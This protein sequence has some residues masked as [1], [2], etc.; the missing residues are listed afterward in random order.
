MRHVLSPFVGHAH[1]TF[2]TVSMLVVLLVGGSPAG[3]L[4][5][6]D[7]TEVGP[8]PASPEAADAYR[9]AANLQN[10]AEFTA[11]TDLWRTFLQQYPDDP[12]V[13]HAQYYLG[14]C[15]MQQDQMDEAATQFQQATNH[16]AD[17]KYVEES[18]LNWGWCRY[19]QGMRGENDQLAEAARIFAD[20]LARFPRGSFT[21]QALF[22]AGECCH[23]TG[24]PEQAT[25]YHQRLLEE[26]PKSPQRPDAMYALAVAAQDSSEHQRAE[27]L[28]Q[29][30]LSEYP[31]HELRAEMLLRY[32]EVLL[33]TGQMDAAKQRFAEAAAAPGFS[34]ADHAAMRVGACLE[35]SR[36]YSA[37]AAYYV[38]FSK[39]FPESKFLPGAALGAARSY[40]EA[41]QWA[42]AKTWYIKARELQPEWLGEASHWLARIALE[43]ADP[44]QAIAESRSAVEKLAPSD[45]WRTKLLLDIAD[46]LYAQPDRKEDAMRAYLRLADKFAASPEAG[47]ALYNAAYAALELGKLTEVRDWTAR[48]LEQFPEHERYP[49]TRHLQGEAAMLAGEFGSAEATFAKLIQDYPQHTDVDRWRT[50]RGAALQSLGRHDEA[51]QALAAAAEQMKSDEFQAEAIYR[52]AVSQSEQGDPALAITSLESALQKQ[53]RNPQADRMLLLLASLEKQQGRPDQAQ[54]HL[55]ALRDQ[56]PDSD[57]RPQATFQL[58]EQ[59]FLAGD[60]AGADPLYAELISSTPPSELVPLAIY[61]QA[62]VNLRQGK[63]KSAESLFSQ[64]I[65]KHAD[66]SIAPRSLQGRGI[67]RHRQR[68]YDAGLADCEAFLRTEPTADLKAD[69]LYVAGLCQIG[70]GQNAAAEE[71]LRRI[72]QE[73]ADYARRDHVIYEL[74]WLLKQPQPDASSEMFEQLARECPDSKLRAESLVH[75]ADGRMARQ[76]YTAAEEY[77]RQAVSSALTDTIAE[78]ALYKLGFLLLRNQEYAKSQQETER[79]LERFPEG[80][81]AAEGQF[82]LAEAHFHQKAYQEA[83]RH[84]EPLRGVT[85]ASA[86]STELKFLHAGQCALQLQADEQALEWLTALY[87]R[88][89]P[90]PLKWQ[91]RFEMAQAWRHQKKTQTSLEAYREVADESR[92]T[93]GA[94]AR[95]MLAEVL[96]G[97]NKLGAALTEF[98]KLIY[99]YGGEQAPAATQEWQRKGALEAG[100]CAASLARQQPDRRAELLAKA[101]KYLTFVTTNAPDS[102]E[103]RAAKEQLQQLGTGQ[104]VG[105]K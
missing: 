41:R 14:V 55:R 93:T 68:N 87:Q 104:R 80:P 20:F 54:R 4:A 40:F 45:P 42:D 26:F 48:F 3:L 13:P 21:D 92:D 101:Q 49:D 57:V 75:A 36:D 95:F 50:E 27:K 102:E 33:A 15:L 81:L 25:A 79:Q 69:A 91:A 37:A 32:G 88:Q 85:L 59:L 24:Q 47:Q 39:Q 67:A 6:D 52:A 103:G 38:T 51:A 1:R 8:S 73:M 76:D 60:L 30:F 63:L 84:Y 16:E 78:T 99:G 62:W 98:Q 28:F 74:A 83:L 53:P 89:P 2:V 29:S 5:Q 58:A 72:L 71:S 44:Q 96:F 22:Y 61:G 86:R 100:R 18:F 17:N 9:D 35:S 31:Q 66:H 19:S 23:L 43:T 65:E 46:A 90:S 10:N 56:F 64:V 34:M 97:E 70:L 7:E 12:M 94:R 77:L 11:A 82:L 105:R